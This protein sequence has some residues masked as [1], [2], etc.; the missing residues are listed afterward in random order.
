MSELEKLM[1]EKKELERRIG[2]LT[3]GAVVMESVKLDTIHA[4]G[5]NT[6]KWAVSVLYSHIAK[7]GGSYIRQQ[8]NKWVP[9]VCCDNREEAVTKIPEIVKALNEL[10]EKACGEDAKD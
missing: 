5:G 2:L 7:I 8:R 6:G 9:I 4:V 1:Q 3:R 10:Y